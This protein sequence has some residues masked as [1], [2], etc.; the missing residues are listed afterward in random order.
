MIGYIKCKGC[1]KIIKELEETEYSGL[2]KEGLLPQYCGG[3]FSTQIDL[4]E[5]FF[6][7]T[8]DLEVLDDVFGKDDT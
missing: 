5:A 1:G 7:L 2:K 4:D 6:E 3:C 8:E